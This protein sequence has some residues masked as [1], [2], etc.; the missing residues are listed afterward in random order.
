MKISLLISILFFATATFAQ[1]KKLSTEKQIP[2]RYDSI[3]FYD[4]NAD[5]W[6]KGPHITDEQGRLNKSVTQ[7]FKADKATVSGLNKLLKS[8]T[9][10]GQAMATCFEPH[11]GIVYYLGGKPAGS[12][13]ICMDCNRLIA[14]FRIP[15]QE[16]GKQEDGEYVYYIASGMSKKLRKFLNDQLIRNHFSHQLEEGAI[17]D[18]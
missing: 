15:A 17:F 18:E 1:G 8:K 5:H 6:E 7:S 11:L 14:D 2:S 3:V 13:T 9:A 16:Q 10:F 12:I 4:F